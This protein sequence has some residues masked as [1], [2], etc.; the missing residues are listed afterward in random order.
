MSPSKH[1]TKVCYVFFEGRGNCT[2]KKIHII[3]HSSLPSFFFLLAPCLHFALST[4]ARNYINSRMSQL[5]PSLA[6]RTQRSKEPEMMERFKKLKD[7]EA[8]FVSVSERE[9]GRGREREREKERGRDGGCIDLVRSCMILFFLSHSLP[10]F[11]VFV[12]RFLLFLVFLFKANS[13]LLPVFHFFLP[14]SSFFYLL[15]LLV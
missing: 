10:C 4:D 2:D 12:L 1:L 14:S 8:S 3:S 6:A 5:L 11:F 13:S 9:R 7:T 15:P